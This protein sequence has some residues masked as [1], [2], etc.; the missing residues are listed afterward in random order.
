M[1]SNKPSVF[2]ERE[3]GFTANMQAFYIPTGPA[4][5]EPWGFR[6]STG[7]AVEA[8]AAQLEFVEDLGS[9]HAGEPIYDPFLHR[10][11]PSSEIVCG[12]PPQIVKNTPFF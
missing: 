4:F 3:I 10:F 11:V 9:R 12:M 5:F 6:V 8:A 7:V 1:K 2:F